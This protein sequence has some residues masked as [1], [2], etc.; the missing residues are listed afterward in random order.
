M[1]RITN[2]QSAVKTAKDWLTS[3]E[4]AIMDKQRTM[5]DLYVA[6]MNA[7]AD[8]KGTDA[9]SDKVNIAP[10]VAQLSESILDNLNKTLN[11]RF[12]FGGFNTPGDA[13]GSAH[14][15]DQ[16]QRAFSV[17][18]G[19]LHFNG[20]NISQFDGMPATLFSSL[21]HGGLGN[22]PIAGQSGLTQADLDAAIA[23]ADLTPEQMAQF[24]SLDPTTAAT[25]FQLMNDI[26]T[27]IVGPG[28]EMPMTING[29]DLAMFATP[30]MDE[31]GDPVLGADGA[32]VMVM[33]TTWNVA[34]ELYEKLAAGASASE[35]TASIRPIQD[36]QNH[37]LSK[38]AEIG[39]RARRLDLLEARY[40]QDMINY[41][42]MRSE[43]EDV[44]FAE[45]SLHF[46]MA[47]AVYQAA[48]SAGARIIQPTLMDFLR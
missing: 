21:F 4:D 36:G 41:E 20:F 32:R 9:D 38:T 40:E 3:A 29:I 23:A 35:I 28:I 2:F 6:A 8:A 25:M 18:D 44:D 43:A 47:E 7:A 15:S 11:G 31:N 19:A 42:R 27:V 46:A 14:I 48:L 34:N 39:G 17:A 30:L 16:S 33:R 24:G 37:L 22:P 26:P 1:V 45:A 5:A 10:E 13:A 12:L